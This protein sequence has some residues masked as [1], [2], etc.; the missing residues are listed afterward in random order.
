VS[1]PAGTRLGP[2][3]ILAAIGAGG[4]GEVYDARDTRLDRTVAIKV[5]PAAIAGDSE[6]RSRL[7]REARAIAALNHPHICTLH[8]VGTHDGL[9][10]LVMERLEGTT[11]AERLG[12]GPMKLPEALACAIQIADALD[13]A[14]GRGIGHRD[15]KPANIMLTKSGA[16]LLDFGLAKVRPDGAPLGLV[17]GMTRTAPLTGEGTI[18]GTLQYMA[19]E[20]LEGAETDARTDIFAFGAILYEMVSGRRAF[21]GK[22]QA[23]LIAAILAADPP[24]LLKVSPIVPAS[25]DRIVNV[26]LAK[27]PNA[28]WSSIHDVALQLKAIA[29]GTDSNLIEPVRTRSN[30][31]ELAAWII[32]AAS[33]AGLV[34]TAF[35]GRTSSPPPAQDFLS[36]LT[37]ANTTLT[38]GE[39]PLISPD[40]RRVAFV[41]SDR[42]G[43]A[44]LNVRELGEPEG[45]PLTGTD[46]VSQPFWAPDSRR[47][48][49]FADGSLKT[50]ALGGGAPQTLAPA[51]F[52][53]GG[54]WSKDDVI[55]FVPDPPSPMKR[56]AAGGGPVTELPQPDRSSMNFRFFPTFLPDGRHYL[57]LGLGQNR[58]GGGIDVGSIDSPDSRNL[59]PASR[60]SATYA[61]AAGA[62]FLI[63]RRETTLVAQPFDADR[64]ELTGTPQAL[65]EGPGFNAITYQGMFSASLTGA[66]AYASTSAASQL[67]WMDRAGRRLGIVGAP[68]DYNSMCFSHDGKRLIYDVADA[69]TGAVDIWQMD[70]PGGTPLRLTHEVAV[71]FFPVCSPSADEIVFS[72][73]R[74]GP[75]DMYRMPLGTPGAEKLL[76]DLPMATIPS[77]WSRDARNLLLLPLNRKSQR[78]IWVLPLDGGKPREVIATP[79]DER[80][81][82]FSPDGRWL[83]YS[84]ND[85]GRFEVFVTPFPPTG[86]KWQI[87]P[88]GGHQPQWSRDGRELFYVSPDQRIVAV[89]ISTSR[90]TFVPGRQTVVAETR[91]TGWERNSH[92]SQYAFTPDGQRV[93]VIDAAETVRP[94]S[95]VFNWAR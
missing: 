12:H 14:H 47:L 39:P 85:S 2:Y 15:L 43:R 40:G 78:D 30:W 80:S 23:S 22:S 75:P 17:D 61:G 38:P 95:L 67:T 4:M 16:K 26:C 70:L 55:L 21:E 10:F 32:A 71:D 28:R 18:L 83:A 93:L 33:V 45:R 3:E 8:D 92:G 58:T 57:F 42:S 79:A 54:S 37:P 35:F 24:P 68:A 60:A 69:A 1:L 13:R 94:I 51:A 73:L 63:F 50:I 5:L 84:S 27:E 56:V 72:S 89:S 31:R 46:G 66:V 25:L 62:G 20:Q 87:S 36:I 11:L 7:E 74:T 53:R 76:L 29:D 77:D 81:A 65:A 52:P 91:M 59:V 86:A 90:G 41:A 48:G 19:P 49:F 44:M 9:Q 82:R 64:L 6:R 88:S 34:A